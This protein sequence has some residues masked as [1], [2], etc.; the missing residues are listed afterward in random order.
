MKEDLMNRI[1]RAVF[2]MATLA[3]LVMAIGASW[4]P[5]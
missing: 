1:R 2:A 3:A 5:K 4:K